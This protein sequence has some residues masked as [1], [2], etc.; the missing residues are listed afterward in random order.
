MDTSIRL[1][2][3]K[4]GIVKVRKIRQVKMHHNEEVN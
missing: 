4:F 2:L 1:N 3:S